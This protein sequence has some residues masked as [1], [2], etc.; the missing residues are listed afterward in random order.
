VIEKFWTPGRRAWLYGV[1]T[2]LV[3]VLT[4]YGLVTPNM[5]GAWLMVV[6]AILSMGSSTLALKNVPSVE[7]AE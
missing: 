5:G 3:P 7:A 4:A 1:A 2:A 6:A